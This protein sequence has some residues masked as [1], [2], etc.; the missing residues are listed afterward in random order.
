[1]TI[2]VQS[3]E[4]RPALL[5]A[6]GIVKVHGDYLIV[7]R[8]GRL[9]TVR[10]GGGDLRPIAALDAFGGDVDPRGAWYDEMLIAGDTIVVVGYSYARGGTEIG[11]F[12]IAA[13]GIL[14]YRGTYHLRS[15]DYYSSRNYASRLIGSKLVFYS[16][17]YLNPWQPDPSAA[18]PA[19]RK[20]R[21]GATAAD[22]KR[23]APAT[24]IYRTDEPLDPFD[25][26]ALHTVTSCDLAMPELDGM[27]ALPT[28]L[29]RSVGLSFKAP[30]I[31][32]T[33][34]TSRPSRIHVM[35]SATTIATR[36]SVRT[37][38]AAC[39]SP[40][41]PSTAPCAGSGPPTRCS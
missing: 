37:S 30:E 39:R 10:I 24:R 13:D 41:W 26:V 12:R 25:G 38:A 15:N 6:R 16:P 19:M 8:R 33:S 1:M 17:L 11:V 29:K 35:P 22:F 7:L 27:E 18:F 9:F 28:L 34:V 36:L 40:C 3:F 32:A 23:I 2:H 14:S 21:N 4:T 5:S 31:A 20:W